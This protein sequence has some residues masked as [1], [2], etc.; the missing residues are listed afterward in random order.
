MSKHIK[1][2]IPTNTLCVCGHARFLHGK[3][4]H[5]TATRCYLVQADSEGRIERRCLCKSFREVKP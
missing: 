5:D 2:A 4:H 3:P 1:P